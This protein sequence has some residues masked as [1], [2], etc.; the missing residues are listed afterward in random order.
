MSPPSLISDISNKILNKS[1]Y[2]FT[3]G[4]LMFLYYFCIKQQIFVNFSEC[5]FYI[6]N[7]QSIKINDQDN[8]FLHKK[9]FITVEAD[10]WL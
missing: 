2:T 1:G 6:L 4:T 7:S 8:F 3:E 9:T 5:F 10:S